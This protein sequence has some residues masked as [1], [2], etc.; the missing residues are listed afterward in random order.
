MPVIIGGK[1]RLLGAF[2]DRPYSKDGRLL[3]KELNR[4]VMGHGPGA[5]WFE[6]HQLARVLVEE[7]ERGRDPGN[8]VVGVDDSGIPRIDVIWSIVKGRSCL[9]FS[10]IHKARPWFSE[11]NVYKLK[12]MLAIDSFSHAQLKT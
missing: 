3:L 1:P 7:V 11:R 12:E 5:G 9:Q 8:D 6:E 2:A 4:G 10:S